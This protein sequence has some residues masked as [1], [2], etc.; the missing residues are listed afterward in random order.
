VLG[1]ILFLGRGKS[2]EIGGE[3]TSPFYD[4]FSNHLY[5]DPIHLLCICSDFFGAS[6]SFSGTRIILSLVIE[7]TE[8][9]RRRP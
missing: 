4:I 5:H 1:L 7:I 8:C 3:G 2:R 9:G 6:I